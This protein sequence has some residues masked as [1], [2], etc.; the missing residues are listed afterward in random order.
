MDPAAY[1]NVPAAQLFRQDRG[2]QKW[3][4]KK[5]VTTVRWVAAVAT[6]VE[7]LC[8]NAMGMT[9]ISSISVAM[10]VSISFSMRGASSL[11]VSW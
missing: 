2:L 9:H 1:G 11:S 7:T 6:D 4:N 10:P 3:A 8:L 5:G